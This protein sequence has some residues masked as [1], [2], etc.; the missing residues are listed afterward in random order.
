MLE[1]FGVFLTPT[2]LA[3]ACVAAILF[4][5]IFYL[6]PN[7]GSPSSSDYT[8]NKN[9]IPRIF[10]DP[11]IRAI[12]TGSLGNLPALHARHG[13]L[14]N[15][16]FI[17]EP[18]TLVGGLHNIRAV[19]NNENIQ[20]SLPKT[21][22]KLLG[23]GNLQTIHGKQHARDRKIMAPIFTP[24]NLKGYI[25]RVADLAK[26]T[27]SSWERATGSS[28][29][30][31]I[32]K[33]A[34]ASAT[35]DCTTKG[36]PITSSISAYHEIRKYVLRVGLELVL[37]FDATK[38]SPA[39]YDRV[40]QLFRELW[41]GFFTVPFDLPGSNYRKAIKAQNELKKTIL[42]NL[43]E[44]LLVIEK[45]APTATA[46]GQT[47]DNNNTNLN[48]NNND[49][50]DNKNDDTNEG[51]RTALELLLDSKD[52]DG[53]PVSKD[54][55]MTLLTSLM[56]GALDT[57]ATTLML[58][59]RRFALH[60]EVFSKARAEQAEIIEKYGSE[61]TFETLKHMRYLDGVLKETIRLQTP[62]QIVFRRAVQDCEIG[63]YVIPA[64]RKILVHVG[65]SIVNDERWTDNYS[66]TST[67]STT[68]STTTNHSTPNSKNSH[69]DFPA[70]Q[71]LPERWLTEEGAKAGG[72]LPFGGGPRLCPGQQLAWTEMKL[73]LATLSRG[74]DVELVDPKEEWDLF[75]LQKPKQG[76]PIKLTKKERL[77]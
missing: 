5:I 30:G 56:L 67:T 36:S 7:K 60:P 38:T 77:N 53:K 42:S 16:T 32:D 13:N 71:F 18:A 24:T 43:E 61:L 22:V 33:S 31:N 3:T 73:L 39:E 28:R 37:G 50:D 11:A 17:G 21:M 35:T 34:T 45:E 63:G 23:E 74:Y 25:P 41:A 1:A 76:M 12:F 29:G 59:V 57:T 69:Q 55:I 6:S 58:A 20:A 15:L 10:Y 66:T 46:S 52:E 40:S 9:K 14:I 65:E 49:D 70:S 8:I 72:W 2:S 44:M 47:S 27:V 26:N 19:L 4:S 75:P 54:H 48:N 64:G 62:V 68:T 51:G